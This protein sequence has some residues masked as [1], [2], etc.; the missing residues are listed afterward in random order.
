[1]GYT[2]R[3]IWP[4]IVKR[5]K[6]RFD[7]TRCS[8]KA[9]MIFIY[10]FASILPILF[11]SIVSF[12]YYSDNLTVK[13]NDLVEYNLI[14]TKGRIETTV[15]SYKHICYR[16]ASDSEIIKLV[17]NI[18]EGTELES[19]TASNKLKNKFAGYSFLNSDIRSIAFM[20]QNHEV[21]FYDKK[22]DTLIGSIWS[23]E[24][25][26]KKIYNS[27]IN[28]SSN[29]TLMPSSVQSDS[30]YTNTCLLNL[31]I[32]IRD[33][34]KPKI[35][36][37][38]VI[39]IDADVI[40]NICN[41]DYGNRQ[42][43]LV[44]TYSFIVNDSGEIISF[45]DKELI[46]KTIYDYIGSN[47]NDKNIFES[48]IKQAPLFENK[49]FILNE[50]RIDELGWTII[51]IVDKDG[52]FRDLYFF[53]TIL[54]LLGTIIIIF[55]LTVI[56]LYSSSFTKSV[57]KII[58]AMNMVQKGDLSVQVELKDKDEIATI[59]DNFN[60]MVQTISDLL[61]KVTAQGIYINEVTRKHKEAEIKALQAQ[62]NPHFI[63]NTL[64]CINWMA[65]DKKEYEISQM[66]KKLANI[67]RY[68]I[69]NINIMVKVREEIEWLEQYVY[70]QQVR[71]NN[72]FEYEVQVD[73]RTHD[74][75]IHKLLLQPFIENSIIHGFED[76]KKGGRLLVT[77]SLMDADYLVFHIEDNGKGISKDKLEN[78]RSKISSNYD[79]ID[80]SIGISNVYN[81]MRMYY[82][83]RGKVEIFSEENIG[84]TV[85]LYIPIN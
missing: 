63:Y 84:T 39:G 73:D 74:Y 80:E 54:I 25:F 51:N 13:I 62:I 70:L 46:G 76:C 66:L 6:E 44:G 82:D 40:E 19:A 8:L 75:Y 14:H 38:I 17:K 32:P 33:L 68:T 55:S 29:I 28:S 22:L 7:Y 11:L 12:K 1:M 47:Y 4:D 52:L 61:K 31:A 34:I 53:R 57:Q 10:I 81:R 3:K 69:S 26:N 48:F 42:K 18:N 67:L 83:D 21:V 36:G 16:I 72:C 24:K 2:D 35:Y 49:P 15:N 64:D 37:I 85:L 71:F 77:V 20:N 43:R 30:V 60:K 56:L 78:I 5:I 79:V 45:L 23:N 50:K 9:K 59:G 65:I 41:P 27:S 58:N